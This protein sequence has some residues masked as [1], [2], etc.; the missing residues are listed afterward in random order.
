MRELE[1]LKKK[2]EQIKLLK[3]HKPK[4]SMMVLICDLSTRRLRQKDGSQ[5]RL[6]SETL[7]LKHKEAQN[8]LNKSYL[9]CEIFP[10][11]D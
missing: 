6:R 8:K 11:W 5:P 1:V 7:S 9:W 3:G 4:L 10:D 2:K